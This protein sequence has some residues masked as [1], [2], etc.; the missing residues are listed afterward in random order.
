MKKNSNYLLDVMLLALMAAIL[1]TTG[2]SKDDNSNAG[3]SQ[4]SVR[5]TDAPGPYDAVNIDIQGV[6]VK[7]N[8]GTFLLNINSGIYNL[9]DFVNGVDTLIAQAGIPSGKV[10]QVR[11]ILGP[12]NTVVVGGIAY[13]LGTPSAQE[14]GLKLNLHADLEPGVAYMLLLDFDVAR[15]IVTNGNGGYSLKPVIRVIEQ[16]LGGSIHGT[17]SPPAA[18]PLV[19]AV[20]GSDTL[21]T[22][23]DTVSGEYLFSGVPAGTYDVSFFPVAPYANQTVNGVVVT[24]GNLTEMG[25]ISF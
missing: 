12:G 10:S 1:F 7:S 2:C 6:E 19:I 22:G 25:T 8:S 21:S 23:C 11:L 4:F 9:L 5:L 3:D 24:T 14:S 13:P 18:Q 16:A 17:V 15:S 20:M